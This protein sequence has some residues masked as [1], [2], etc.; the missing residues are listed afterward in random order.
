MIKLGLLDF[1]SSHCVEFTKRLNHVGIVEEQFVDGAKVVLAYP[2][3]SKLSPERIPGFTKQMKKL[4]V[5]LASKPTDFLGKVD[6]MLIESVDGSVHLERAKPFL[7]AGLPC[8][9]DKPFT[10]SVA[11]AKALI[12]L[13][14]RKK[15]PIFSSSSLRYAPELVQYLA[16]AA[17]G[18]LTGADVWGPALEHP[19]N[20]GLF[21]YGIHAVE[22]L[23]TLLGPGCQRVSCTYAKGSEV[24]TGFWQDGR[25]GTVRGLRSGASG[26]GFTA[27]AAKSIKSVPVGT[28]FIYR[29]LL[30]QVVKCFQT[31]QPPISPSVTLELVSFIESAHRSAVNHGSVE[32]L[33][34]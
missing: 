33:K 31:G 21:H 24:V 32:A 16:D 15:V 2:G 11:D 6:A 19:R 30:K 12:E 22:M 4:G 14:D 28:T 1:D 29:E 17:H 7:E 3:E 26:F 10:C 18:P 8:F 34:H 13:A 27:F 25:V 23:Y 5:P 9:V 20:P